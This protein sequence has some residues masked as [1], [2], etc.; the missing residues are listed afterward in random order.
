MGKRAMT[1]GRPPGR[2]TRSQKS[3]L[4]VV[5]LFSGCGGLDLGFAHEGFQIDWAGDIMPDAVRT[6][7]RNVDDRAALMDITAIDPQ[8]LPKCDVVIG[9]PPCQAFSLVGKRDPNDPRASL[10]QQ[11]LR[12]IQCVH[13]RVF[14]MENVLGLRSARDAEGRPVMPWLVD[15]FNRLG[16]GVVTYIL[17]AADYGVPQR[18]KRLFIIGSASG[19]MASCPLATH[20]D[21]LATSGSLF[22]SLLPWVTS[23][24]ALGD[25]S[26]PSLDSEQGYYVEEATCAFQEYA[27]RAGGTTFG[28]HRMPY[29]SKKDLEIIY[30]AH[31]GGNFMDVPDEIAT[32]RILN[33]KASGGRTTTY[34]RLDPD[35]PAYTINT[36]FS[37]PN[38]GCNIHYEQDRLITVREGLRLQS[39]PDWFSVLVSSKRSG[40]VQVG[41][42]VPPL[43]AAAVAREVKRVLA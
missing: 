25:L 33:F 4:R 39:F 34:G 35:R 5:S 37:R 43:L 15:S 3:K 31:P 13:P 30:A 22:S 23:E 32:K 38:V 21:A 1:M 14:V 24:E 2:S 19:R 18:R 6:Y 9:G 28:N 27:R 10:V 20:A 26:V 41:N 40:Y 17:N 12:I 42:A 7:V 29:M 16:Y 11:Y 8:D 36:N